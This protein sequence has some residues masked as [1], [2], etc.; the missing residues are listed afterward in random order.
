MQ[1]RRLV[2][3]T[4]RVEIHCCSWCPAPRGKGIEYVVLANNLMISGIQRIKNIQFKA[5]AKIVR[6]MDNKTVY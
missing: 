1:G 5:I 4:V 6:L 3:R 2:Y